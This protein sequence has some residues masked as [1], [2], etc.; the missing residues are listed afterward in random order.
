[1]VRYQRALLLLLLLVG[2]DATNYTYYTFGL[3]RWCNQGY[4]IHGLWPQYNHT[5]YPEFCGVVPYVNPI[6]LSSDIY[7]QMLKKWI[8]C[9][10]DPDVFWMHEWQKHGSCAYQQ[11]GMNELEYFNTTLVLYNYLQPVIDKWCQDATDD[12]CQTICMD[13]ALTHLFQCP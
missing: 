3:Q 4:M 7:D 6:Y 11:T 12:I 5:S 2:S 13:L 8:T 10:E 1:M 9:N